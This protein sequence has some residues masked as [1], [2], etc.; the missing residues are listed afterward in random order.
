MVNRT[1]TYFAFDGLGE[2]DPTK[3]DFRYYST[4]QAWAAG[5]SIEFK[6]VNSHDKASA[7]RDTSKK[8]TLVASIQQRL[9]ASKNMVVIA[10]PDTRK[11]GSMLSYEIEK[12]IDTYDIPL[13]VAYTGYNSIVNPRALASRWPTIL[14]DRI[15]SKAADAIHIPFKQAALLDAISRFSVNANRP[16]GPLVYYT[17]RKHQEW[18]YIS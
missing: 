2:A 6:F 14:A 3:S 10:S 12:A 17:K 16:G 15:N 8:A 5:K 11:N 9:R 7:V 18:G 1:G 4:A 13:I